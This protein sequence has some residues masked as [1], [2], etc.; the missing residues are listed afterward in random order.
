MD[1]CYDLLDTGPHKVYSTLQ[2]PD[3]EVGLTNWIV[4]ILT[5]W[6]HVD[7]WLPFDVEAEGDLFPSD[8]LESRN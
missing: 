1:E 5:T 7:S 4:C 2:H 6:N 3:D 8:S